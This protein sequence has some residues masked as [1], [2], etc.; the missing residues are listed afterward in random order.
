M[1]QG[2]LDRS[3]TTSSQSQIS[4]D[5]RNCWIVTAYVISGLVAFIVLAYYLSSYLTH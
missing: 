1:E 5:Q 4:R 3:T 2:A